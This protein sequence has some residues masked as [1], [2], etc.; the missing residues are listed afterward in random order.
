M[1][2]LVVDLQERLVIIGQCG[3]DKTTILRLI[4]GVLKPDE[5]SELHS[6][7][8]RPARDCNSIRQIQ[9]TNGRLDH[10]AVLTAAVTMFFS[11]AWFIA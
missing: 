2:S 5:G 7:N 4:L 9:T 11:A 8:T 10:F 6:A 1:V 3:A